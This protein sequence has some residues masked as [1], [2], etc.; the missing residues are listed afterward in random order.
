MA[1]FSRFGGASEDWNTYI[2]AN[3]Q[4]PMLSD[5]TPV[6]LQYRTNLGRESN[7]RE[8]LHTIASNI[9]PS[10]FTEIRHDLHQSS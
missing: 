9:S 4:L 2:E 3:P 5:L 10:D 7:S 8:I 1:D 6:Q